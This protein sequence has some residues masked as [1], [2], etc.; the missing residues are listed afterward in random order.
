MRITIYI[1]VDSAILIPQEKKSGNENNEKEDCQVISYKEDEVNKSKDENL[2]EKKGKC[3]QKKGNRKQIYW[4]N[5][6][7]KN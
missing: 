3:E 2:R 6:E 1:T 4:T 7:Q 5:N